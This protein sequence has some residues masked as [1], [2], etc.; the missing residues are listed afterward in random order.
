MVKPT[1]MTNSAAASLAARYQRDLGEA[2]DGVD[3][4][5]Y[6]AWDLWASSSEA[7]RRPLADDVNQPPKQVFRGAKAL[8]VEDNELNQE[9]A[10][11]S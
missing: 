6:I 9:V 7:V 1:I 8:L 5:Q 4:F 2:S 10:R 3:T 11:R